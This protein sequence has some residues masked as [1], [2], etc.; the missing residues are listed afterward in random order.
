M[1]PGPIAPSPEPASTGDT[2]VL[3]TVIAPSIVADEPRLSVAELAL[4]LATP[5]PV[6]ADELD[7]DIDLEAAFSTAFSPDEST[8]VPEDVE[9]FLGEQGAEPERTEPCPSPLAESLPPPGVAEVADIELPDDV[10][11]S[12][13]SASAAP[14][15]PALPEPGTELP[16]WVTSRPER[17]ELSPLP[18][19]ALPRPRESNVDELLEGMRSE[20]LGEDELRSVLKGLAGLDPTP[21]PPDAPSEG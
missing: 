14:S 7:I 19:V 2:P 18:H 11:A 3:G 4:S 17:H 15:A 6:V 5:E 8:V 16:P 13:P 9:L 20:S 12:A 1:P 10:L 21:P